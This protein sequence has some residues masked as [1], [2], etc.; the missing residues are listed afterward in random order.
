MSQKLPFNKIKILVVD[1]QKNFQF[2][3]RGMLYNFGAKDIEFA[4]SGES[5]VRMSRRTKYDLFLVEYSLGTNKNGR[6]LL[7]ELKYLKL[8]KPD[9]MFVIVSSESSRAVVL[10]TL[11]HLPDDYIIKPF[12]QRLLS[13]RLQRAWEKRKALSAI[14]HN[15]HKGNDLGAIEAC[16]KLIE[17]KSRYSAFCIQMTAELYCKT[18]QFAKAEDI[19]QD[20]LA[21][22]E[23]PWAKLGLARAYIGQ[24][25]ITDSVKILT[26]V[27]KKQNWN[28]EAYDLLAQ[29]QI[30]SENYLEAQDTLTKATDISPHSIQRQ[31]ELAQVAEHNQDFEAAKECY[32]KILL[33]SRKSIHSGMAH[34]CNY[35]RS[36]IKAIEASDEKSA[37]HR[38]QQDLNT[39]L[40]QAKTE[41]GRNL[42]FNYSSLEG[43]MQA[44]LHAAKG[45]TIKAKKTLMD[46]LQPFVDEEDGWEIPP[47]LSPD[48]CATLL[49]MRDYEMAAEVAQQLDQT[50]EFS[51]KLLKTLESDEIRSQKD[52]FSTITQQGIAAYS[53]GDTDRALELFEEAIALSPANSGAA[54]NL[55]QAQLRKLKES[56]KFNH[57][58]FGA[59]KDT[60]RLLNGVH[61]SPNHKI[62]YRKLKQE[63]SEIKPK[64]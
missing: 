18:G 14:H 2:M 54:L 22:R 45:E 64:R 20:V 43:V 24:A 5:A 21:E 52:N 61:L 16:Q 36:I 31:K 41:E 58:I 15:L 51:Q 23:M 39:A 6:Q 53:G 17:Q 27:I 40:F 47:Q 26:G 32:N 25:K 8:L 28:V 4:E 59:C 12:S 57:E 62:R 19:L 63:F 34:L 60:F 37:V 56:R 46:A 10:G 33:L 13:H 50:D 35:L 49:T 44:Q 3:M 30:N 55:I 7:E 11:E 38:L 9:A 42:D 48:A 1:P 29:A